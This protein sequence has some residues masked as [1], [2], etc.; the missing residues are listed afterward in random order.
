[1]QPAFKVAEQHGHRLD[2]L[3]VGQVPEPLFANDVSR[4]AALALLFRLQIQFF[5]F[6]IR[7]CQ[8]IP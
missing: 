7:Q 4:K 5:Q 1:M 8:E 2:P 3:F 6:V